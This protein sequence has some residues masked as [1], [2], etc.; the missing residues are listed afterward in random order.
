L[1]KVDFVD[2][3]YDEENGSNA[4]DEFVLV[5]D[6]YKNHS[7][8]EILVPNVDKYQPILDE[9]SDDE[10]HIFTKSHIDLISSQQVYDSEEDKEE[11][12]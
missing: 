6:V 4:V 2:F 3:S 8:D 10:E 1:L 5:T 7:S 11:L 12:Q 9:Y